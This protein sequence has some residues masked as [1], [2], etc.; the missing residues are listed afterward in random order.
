MSPSLNHCQRR[1]LY[2]NENQR[3]KTRRPQ[4]KAW[5]RGTLSSVWKELV[6]MRKQFF[7]GFDHSGAFEKHG[8]NH[9]KVYL[10]IRVSKWEA[11]S[12]PSSATLF[13]S[14]SARQCWELLWAHIQVWLRKYLVKEI[15]RKESR[16]KSNVFP[17]EYCSESDFFLGYLILMEMA[18]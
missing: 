6:L 16:L 4:E 8:G 5:K 14:V 18:R 9:T 1:N 10:Q 2:Q 12:K 7:S 15:V 13:K 11:V 17:K 3:S